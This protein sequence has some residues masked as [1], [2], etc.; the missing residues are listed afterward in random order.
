MRGGEYLTTEVLGAIWALLLEAFRAEVRGNSGSVQ[1]LLAEKNPAWNVVGRVFFHLAEN[2]QSA[3]R[4]FAFLASYTTGLTAQ[5][6]PQ[7]RPLGEAVRESSSAGDKQRLIAL[8][9][10]IQKAAQQ[11][12]FLKELVD[13]G[14]IF[15]PLGW[16]PGQAHRFLSDIP[17]FEQCGL[18]V[19]VPD[20]W[21]PRRPLRPQVTVGI[22]KEKP[23]A[24]GLEAMLDFTVE[25]TLDGKALT[26]AELQALRASTEG[27]MLL[28]GRWVEVDRERLDQALAHWRALEKTAGDGISFIEGMRLIAGAR[29]G[30]DPVLDAD[31]QWMSVEAGPW[32]EQVLASART[33]EADPGPA[34]H[35]QLRPYQAQGV[36]WLHFLSRLRLG[37]CLADDMGLGKTIQVLALL[38]LLKKRNEL[39]GPHLL[40]VPA[41]LIANW[42]AEAERFTPS[43]RILIA[44][45]SQIAAKDLA[46]LGLEALNEVDL[47]VTSYGSAQRL[48]W[49]ASSRWGL[50]VLDEAQAIKNPGTRQARLVKSLQ[51]EAR[52][53][54]TGTPVENRVGDLWSLFDFLNPGLLGSAKQFT[55]FTRKTESAG[56]LRELT[57]PYL[58][59][60]LKTDKSIISDLPEK[61][62]LKAFCSLSKLQAALYQQAVDE[63]GGRL[64]DATGIARQGLVLAFLIR[65]KQI[66]NHPSQWLDDGNWAEEHSGKFDRLK[67]ICETIAERQEKVLLFT[68]FR[69]MSQPLANWGARLFGR[70][71]LVLT[72]DTPIKQRALRVK[73]FQEDEQVP[74]FV[75]SLKAGG[76]GLNLTAASHVIHF[77]RW[78][79]PA[80]ENQATDRA[81]RIGQKKNVLVHKLIC[82][83]T[84]EER[85]DEM[86]ASKQG[87]AQ[88]LLEGGDEL[89]LTELSDADL[90][91]LVALDIH[92]ARADS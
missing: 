49:I 26:P 84:I 11:S 36:R 85:I 60:R 30:D 57:R 76:T 9:V 75:L 25:V 6:K 27:L 79:N 12:P 33:E 2:K 5:G 54:L 17:T 83:G 81:F 39:A 92:T 38:L 67:Q 62:E 61:T 29:L 63:L 13:A 35:A 70:P 50:V 42:K 16:T 15:Q 31:R 14:H 37:A 69:Q 43:L 19:R 20:W 90:M 32:L 55:A 47:V 91:K 46:A 53:A 56:P 73:Q 72:G 66:C 80:V 88:Q 34:L 65:F 8:L 68:Q 3:E 41:S 21:T 74:F 24:L 4:P 87:L 40:V 45:P 28:K 82:R 51:C 22:G 44:H 71:G 10:P 64:L 78:W 18:V 52:I 48:P 58:L 77:D 7:H 86:L 89:K 59:R 23:S 1:R